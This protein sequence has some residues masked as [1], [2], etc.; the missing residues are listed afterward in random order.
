M[1]AL[2]LGVGIAETTLDAIAVG[3]TGLEAAPVLPLPVLPP[4]AGVSPELV[5]SPPST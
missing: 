2:F 4:A 3:E 1:P 5:S